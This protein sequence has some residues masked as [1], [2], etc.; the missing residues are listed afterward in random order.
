MKG[1][2][3]LFA[4][5]FAMSYNSV[6]T[7][8]I[9]NLKRDFKV[10]DRSS[11]G[12][13][14]YKK[15]KFLRFFPAGNFKVLTLKKSS[16]HMAVGY[17]D[18]MR[19]Y[20]LAQVNNIPKPIYVFSCDQDIVCIKMSKQEEL[21]ATG[22]F[23]GSIYVHDISQKKVIFERTYEG[24]PCNFKFSPNFDYLATVHSNN[25]IT[26]HEIRKS[27][28]QNR[29]CEINL[30]DGP[31]DEE[32]QKFRNKLVFSEDSRYLA[33]AYDL[34]RVVIYDIKNNKTLIIKNRLGN[35]IT[36]V[37]F[38]KDSTHM[39]FCS[40]Y[41]IYKVDIKKAF[42]A[43]TGPVLT[44]TE[45]LCSKVWDSDFPGFIIA[46]LL[47]S[48]D[49]KFFVAMGD[50]EVTIYNPNSFEEFLGLHTMVVT[51]DEEPLF[52]RIDIVGFSLYKNCF[53]LVAEKINNGE[54]MGESF[55][56]MIDICK[57]AERGD[58][59]IHEIAKFEIPDFIRYFFVSPSGAHV[60]VVGSKM[61]VFDLEKQKKIFS[62]TLGYGISP[63][64]RE[65]DRIFFKGCFSQDSDKM[66]LFYNNKLETFKTPSKLYLKEEKT[67]L[68]QK[69]NASFKKKIYALTLQKKLRKNQKALSD[70]IIKTRLHSKKKK[71]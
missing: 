42:Y 69:H 63:V 71:E 46:G 56:S 61:H 59:K 25:K 9:E 23:D 22:Y 16:M 15:F 10:T 21:V 18:A 11:V 52:A 29:L 4:V 66:L 31:G 8:Y 60:A 57:T 28:K 55:I 70:V 30:N 1:L 35:D 67:K 38:S 3:V 41:L 48:D 37:L 27:N 14:L 33:Y 17:D 12:S 26:I 40:K 65:L 20:S 58:N 39:F 5:L 13:D 54:L 44:L 7:F 62:Y 45:N 24:I 47:L 64:N 32:K 36:H 2:K 43:R 49:G 50:H 51:E 6:L 68:K 34:A 53:V 19:V